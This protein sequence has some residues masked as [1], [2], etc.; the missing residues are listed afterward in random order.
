MTDW[1]VNQPLQVGARTQRSRRLL[2]AG[3]YTA[4]LHG[5][6]GRGIVRCY[7]ARGLWRGSPCRRDRCLPRRVTDATADAKTIVEAIASTPC[8]PAKESAL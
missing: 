6:P 4:N 3:W 8:A 5:E 2:S 7:L 1:L